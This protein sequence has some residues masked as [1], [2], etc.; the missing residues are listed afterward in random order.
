MFREDV[1][2][3]VGAYPVV[4]GETGEYEPE[5]RCAPYSTGH[6]GTP[7]DV[8]GKRSYG[9]THGGMYIGNHVQQQ[10]ALDA[11]L[12]ATDGTNLYNYAVWAY[13]PVRQH[14]M[15]NIPS[16]ALNLSCRVTPGIMETASM[17]KTS[18]FGAPTTTSTEGTS[19]LKSLPRQLRTTPCRL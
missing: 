5:T 2:Q 10:K 6:S 16:F 15:F 18:Q 3:K 14:S 12:N 13:N 4:L 7:Y 9:R 1:E 11:S 19:N 17:L 8:D